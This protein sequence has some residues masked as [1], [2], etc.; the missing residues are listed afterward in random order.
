M[1][2]G[3]YIAIILLLRVV[4]AFFNKRSSMEIKSIPM[5]IGYNS[6][7]NALSALL[8][9]FL[10]LFAGNGFRADLPT[11]LIAS[12]SGIALFFSGF[13]S[14]YAMKSGTVSLSS[15]FGTAGM[16]I[17]IAAGALFFGQ[18][19]KPM[20]LVGMGLFFVSAYLLICSSKE[21]YAGFDLKTL[22]L[23]TGS[24]VANGCTMLAQQMFTRYVPE[25]DVSVF[26]FLSFAI[27][28][29]L[30]GLL[31]G[32]IALGKNKKQKTKDQE[33]FAPSRALLLCGVA[34]AVS[35]FVIN[36]LATLS[37]ALISP[38]ILF[39]FINGGGTIISAIVAAV[40]YREKLTGK[41]C[42]GILLGV[43]SLLLIK[44]FA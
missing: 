33:R 31:Y 10:I 16:L 4:Q 15:M 44:A 6:Y 14:I 43:A 20:Q 11:V 30:S 8:G 35:V 27:I 40:V 39:A 28:A 9:V 25:G 36:Q 41:S 7:K 5:L 1:T 26:S 18:P 21:I 17:P 22:L 2:V 38:V 37:T 23:L 12:F 34:L 3:I 42:A 19:V 24:L 32:G 29:L 13:C